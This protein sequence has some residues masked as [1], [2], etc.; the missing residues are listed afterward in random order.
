MVKNFAKNFERM[1]DI[2]F[3][4]IAPERKANRAARDFVRYFHGA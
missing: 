4:I 1:V 3:S 2:F